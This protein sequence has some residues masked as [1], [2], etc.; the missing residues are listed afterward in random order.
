MYLFFN[1][2]FLLFWN[3]VKHKKRVT[4]RFITEKQTRQEKSTHIKE[5]VRQLCVVFFF[6]V[7]TFFSLLPLKPA[8][9]TLPTLT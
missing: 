3:E 8:I 5:K 9:L 2:V 6:L 7:K 1:I 4:S